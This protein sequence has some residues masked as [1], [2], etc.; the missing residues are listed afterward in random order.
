MFWVTT[1]IQL[2]LRPKFILLFV[3]FHF[4]DVELRME[5]T[6]T[7]ITGSEALHLGFVADTIISSTH[8]NKPK[9]VIQ[10]NSSSFSNLH[11]TLVY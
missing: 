3:G 9:Q 11:P 10:I 2:P 4:S 6:Q 5:D 8:S 1:W 7:P